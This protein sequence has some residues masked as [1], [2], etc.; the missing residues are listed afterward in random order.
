M[1]KDKA[2][3]KPWHQRWRDNRIGFHREKPHPGLVSYWLTLNLNPDAQI[4]VP[5]CGKSLDMLWLAEH[6]FRVIGVELSPIAA[7]AFF[8]ENDLQFYERKTEAF[9]VFQGEKITILVGDFFDLTAKD[10]ANV[11]AVYDRAALIALPLEIRRKY[12]QHLRTLITS[13]TQLLIVTMSYEQSKLEGPPF[14]VTEDEIT[15]QFGRWCTIETLDRSKPENF[16]GVF[17][18]EHVF[19]LNRL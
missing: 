2:R 3:H 6:G 17:A 13:N 5:L 11:Q 15:Q 9:R 12:C 1:N 18:H 14:S 19:L 4:F 16:R 10:L 8:K 7:R